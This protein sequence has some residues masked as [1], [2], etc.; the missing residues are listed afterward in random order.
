MPATI[1][2]D[3][4][5]FRKR[6]TVFSDPDKYP[7]ETL[8]DFWDQATDYIS[9]EDYGWLS[10]GK[11]KS[12]INMMTAHL[13]ALNDILTTGESEGIGTGGIT[14]SATIDKVSVTQAPPPPASD[15]WQYWLSQ[16]PYGLEL[17]A[18]LQVHSVGGFYIGG[19]PERSAFRKVGGVF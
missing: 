16:T 8:Q 7:T 10:G 2:F 19:L 1:T 12:A 5:L 3:A 15:E 6:F 13:L 14:T 4:I 9:S 17:L 18:L 11:R